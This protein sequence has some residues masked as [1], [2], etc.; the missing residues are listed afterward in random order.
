VPDPSLD[1]V[2]G[3]PLEPEGVLLKRILRVQVIGDKAEPYDKN[4][5][6]DQVQQEIPGKRP[7]FPGEEIL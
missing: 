1:I 3:L 2:F 6:E 5:K 4:Q 7:V